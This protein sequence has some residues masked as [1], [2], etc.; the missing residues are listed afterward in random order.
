MV[1]KSIINRVFRAIKGIEQW[2][3]QEATSIYL[4]EEKVAPEHEIVSIW[5]SLSVKD[6]TQAYHVNGTI[7]FEEWVDMEEIRRRIKEL[8]GVEY[9][10]FRSLYPYI[11][12]LVDI[13]LMETT[14]AGG[15]RKWR[16][17]ALFAERKKE[18]ETKKVEIRAKN[19]K[20][21][22]EE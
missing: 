2:S 21:E 3:E 8:F 4:T 14:S 11:K 7:G 22:K 10:N 19:E 9:K 12:T 5:D 6:N 15:R 17:V 18:E 13:G 1:L 16:K 20:N